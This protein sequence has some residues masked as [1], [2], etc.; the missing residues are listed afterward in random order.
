MYYKLSFCAPNSRFLQPAKNGRNNSII[1]PRNTIV[2]DCV[3]KQLEEVL[4]T[5]FTNACSTN[6]ENIGCGPIKQTP[7]ADTASTRRVAMW[8]T[9][10]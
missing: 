7:L 5:A 1:F 10:I 2:I 3:N 8:V 9:G 6:A 4:Y